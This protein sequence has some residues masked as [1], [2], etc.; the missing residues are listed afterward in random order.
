MSIDDG[1]Q[2]LAR[3]DYNIDSRNGADPRRPDHSGVTRGSASQ[4]GNESNTLC[5]R[6]VFFPFF[7][8]FFLVR[9]WWRWCFKPVRSITPIQQQSVFVYYAS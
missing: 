8:S 9:W 5:S 6:R 2:G 4:I 7:V 1:I 3:W